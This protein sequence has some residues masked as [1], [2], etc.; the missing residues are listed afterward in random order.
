M[1]ILFITD[2]YKIDNNFD[3]RAL[4]DF[5]ETWLAQGHRV[6]VIRPNFLFNTLLRGKKISKEGLFEENGVQV[7]NLNFITPFWFNVFDKL[8]KGFN[9]KDYDVLISHMPSGALFSLRLTEKETIPFAVSVHCSDIEVLSTPLYSVYFKKKLLEMYQKA[10]VISPRS[11]HLKDK[12]QQYIK[13]KKIFPALS[14]I[15][16]NEILSE[17]ELAEKIRV[18]KNKGKL[19]IT[20]VSDLIKRKNIDVILKALSKIKYFDFEFRIIGSGKEMG[21]LVSLTKMMKLEDKVKFFGKIPHSEVLEKLKESNIFILLSQRET[22]GLSYL[23]AMAKGNITVCS[24]NEGIDGIIRDG[25][26]GF[27]LGI[28]S[29]ELAQKLIEVYNLQE[30]EIS[31]LLI[32]TRKTALENTLSTAAERYL[33]NILH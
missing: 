23:E 2:L 33:N 25:E 26:N 28:S 15:R 7:L 24:K 4:N 22:F 19:I 27:S 30:D 14:G 29:D 16:K 3:S 6:F 12:I 17:E 5:A 13:D 11:F 31:E 9:L 20:T 18:F 21:R 1:K 10:D 8:P 32:N